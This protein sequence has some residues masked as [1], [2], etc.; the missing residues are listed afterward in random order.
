M[1]KPCGY[2]SQCD[3]CE[4]LELVPERIQTKSTTDFKEE[5]LCNLNNAKQVT[6][7]IKERNESV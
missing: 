1:W 3:S 6:L 4:T 7:L 5:E 2:P